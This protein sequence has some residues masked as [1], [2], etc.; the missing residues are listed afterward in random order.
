MNNA[1]QTRQRMVARALPL[2]TVFFIGAKGRSCWGEGRHRHLR[3][4]PCST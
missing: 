3:Q 4:W 1:A 2:N